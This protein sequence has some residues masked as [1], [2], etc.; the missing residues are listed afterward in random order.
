MSIHCLYYVGD[1]GYKLLIL[2]RH[3]AFSVTWDSMSSEIAKVLKNCQSNEGV[4][5]C[6]NFLNDT[7][8]Y[9]WVLSLFGSSVKPATVL[10]D[11]ISVSFSC[12]KVLTEL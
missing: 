5:D 10:F 8:H 12:H 1:F 9:D 4:T 6:T 7:H 11:L 2:Y 3:A